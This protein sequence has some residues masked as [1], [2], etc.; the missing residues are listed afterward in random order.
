MS[1]GA[2]G[3][4]PSDGEAEAL[5]A[6]LSGVPRPE[7]GEAGN[8]RNGQRPTDRDSA[9]QSGPTIE[10]R[11]AV[12]LGWFSVGLG[13]PQVL[14]PGRVNRLIGIDDT[15]NNRI[16]MR[17]IGARELAA[18]AGVFSTP[19]PA[20][21]LWA[22]VAGDAMDLALLAGAFG[23]KGNRKGRLAMASAAVAGVT[24]LDV[25]ASTRLSRSTE[26]DGTRQVRVERSATIR[27]SPEELYRAWRDPGV[28][29][30]TMGHFA[31]I[32]DGK[33]GRTHW[34]VRGPLR[35]TLE[36][37]AQITDDRPGEL[38]R[39]ESVGGAYIPNGGSVR[40][41]PAPQ[42][43]GSEVALELRFMPPVGPLGKAAAKL[44]RLAPA[45]LAETALRRFKSLV[46]AGEIPT[47]EHDPSARSEGDDSPCAHSDTQGE[48]G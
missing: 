13:I 44:G 5:G 33:A 34:T 25:F 7:D 18:G 15:T 37:D 2:S 16:L 3:T 36:W 42:D 14:V 17:V 1:S 23:S 30:Q 47:T 24:V 8:G 28:L 20:G 6:T 45:M 31:E 35:R 10:E 38:L 39:W 40:F 19:R 11:L 21:W 41:R 4:G 48:A 26:R 29:G 27:K 46:E 43:W 32:V 22:R 9:G 12:A